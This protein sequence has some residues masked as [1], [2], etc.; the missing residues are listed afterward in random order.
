MRDYGVV[1]GIDC[2]LKGVILLIGYYHQA[3]MA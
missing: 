3:A 1:H 2:H